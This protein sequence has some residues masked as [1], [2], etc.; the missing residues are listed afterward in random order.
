MAAAATSEGC[1]SK[2]VRC[3]TLVVASRSH[4]CACKPVATRGAHDLTPAQLSSAK[5]PRHERVMSAPRGSSSAQPQSA[6]LPTPLDMLFRVPQSTRNL[7]HKTAHDTECEAG[8][9]AARRW[10]Q[11]R[12]PAAKHQLRHTS[13]AN[14]VHTCRTP[15]AH[16]K[17]STG[18]PASK[19]AVRYGSRRV[20]ATHTSCPLLRQ[21]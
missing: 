10:P 6:P 19:D 7:A 12:Q 2:A 11:L 13:C 9:L 15:R 14:R 4:A 5:A 20:S 18:A 21:H 17:R 1:A 3:Q 8:R 16:G